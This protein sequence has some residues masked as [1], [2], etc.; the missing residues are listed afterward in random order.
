MLFLI[1]IIGFIHHFL[2]DVLNQESLDVL[3]EEC[4]YEFCILNFVSNFTRTKVTAF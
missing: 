4:F 1:I 3:N 2:K